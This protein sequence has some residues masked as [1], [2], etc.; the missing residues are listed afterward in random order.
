[1]GPFQK[2]EL[3]TIDLS[4]VIFED[5]VEG[6]YYVS[7]PSPKAALPPIDLSFVLFEDGDE[8]ETSHDYVPS[9]TTSSPTPSFS[10]SP[11][12]PPASST[13]EGKRKKL[14]PADRS[15]DFLWPKGVR[16]EYLLEPSEI[17]ITGAT[18]NC[19]AA[20]FDVAIINGPREQ[21][22]PYL[23][24]NHN[25]APLKPLPL[26]IVWTMEEEEE[27]EEEEIPPFS[28]HTAESGKR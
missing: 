11:C 2:A 14:E 13:E 9:T 10:T 25:W 12:L 5:E 27:E 22:V 17:K 3:T 21:V 16:P 15:T 19:Y 20:G 23:P 28:L 24:R 7:S 18:A 6:D 1:M 8:D 26:R 4:S